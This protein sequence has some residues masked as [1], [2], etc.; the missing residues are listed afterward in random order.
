MGVKT[1]TLGQT[2]FALRPDIF[3][4]LVVVAVVEFFVFFFFEKL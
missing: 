1:P 4:F 3:Y 2:F